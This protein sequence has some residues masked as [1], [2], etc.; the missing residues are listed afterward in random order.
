MNMS[1]IFKAAHA[2]TKATIQAGDSYAVTFAAALKICIADAKAPK[3]NPLKAKVSISR[4]KDNLLVKV[5]FD[6][7]DEFKKVVRA[8]W[9]AETKEWIVSANQEAAL[10]EWLAA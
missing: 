4:F 9:A 1:Q 3:T 5:P 10:K 2:L 6:I 7:K 8:K